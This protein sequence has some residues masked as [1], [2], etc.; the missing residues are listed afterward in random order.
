MP[1]RFA[2]RRRVVHFM[3]VC[4]SRTE[5]FVYDFIHGCQR[6]KAWCLAKTIEPQPGFDFAR[7]CRRTV[8]WNRRSF[9]D[10]FDRA[11]YRL[12]RRADVA[13]YRALLWIRPAVLH[14]HFGPAGWEALPYAQQLGIPLL[15]SFYGYDAS[16]LPRQPGWADR[17]QQ[18][19]AIGSGFLV[20]GPA[21]AR[22]LEGLGCPAE[23]IHLLPITLD[24]DNYPFRPRR[25]DGPEPLRLLFVGRF[26]PKKGLPILLNALARV[27]RE[28]IELRVIGGGAGEDEARTLV[29]DLGL[30][31]RVTFLGFQ[32]RDA[33]IREM[34]EA[35]MLAV[36]SVTA[37]DGDTE[38][39]APTI[40]LE[41]QAS[42]LPVLATDHA[43]IPFTVAEPY[44]P[45]LA[46]EGCADSLAD[47]LV[48]LRNNAA[49]WSVLAEAGRRHVAAQH[50]PNNFRHLER[51]YDGAVGSGKFYCTKR[52]RAG[53]KV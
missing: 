15:T 6:Y 16:S 51:L 20:E 2:T 48:A 32:P 47:R 22:R 26:V 34:A 11:C 23:K 10:L 33:V 49:R 31:D 17:L 41:A 3:D 36:P 13:T 24:L 1:L 37:P 9:W 5:T 40:L 28:P 30:G 7:V 39:G 53:A 8:R 18:L 14:A 12:T 25:L 46:A 50:G 44:H 52:P 29:T 35:H 4:F 38:G 27:G 42:G 43:D 19:F 45:Y 21:M